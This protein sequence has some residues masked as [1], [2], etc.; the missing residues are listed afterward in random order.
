MTNEIF[1]Q[2]KADLQCLSYWTISQLALGALKERSIQSAQEHLDQCPRCR[3]LL[4]AE[5]EQVDA[6][7]YQRLPEQ[8]MAEI[9]K[10]E[11][12]TKAGWRLFFGSRLFF[13]GLTV[14]LTVCLVLVIS[15]IVKD[16]GVDVNQPLTRIKGSEGLT[17]S[18]LRGEQLTHN[19]VPLEQVSALSVGDRLR[20]HYQGRQD[21]WLEIYGQEKGI[22]ELYYQGK[23]PL[24]G[25][26][27]MG[28]K[29]TGEEITKIKVL[30]CSGQSGLQSEQI[31]DKSKCS[32][33]VFN[34]RLSNS[35]Q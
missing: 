15:F 30:E 18:V 35:S 29:I 4:R 14:S 3:D 34:L 26:L 16:M 20:L 17:V 24:D 28:I 32:Q 7:R 22:W 31:I 21:N 6:A 11:Q 8:L 23:V 13:P 5:Q 12:R 25:W 19:R 2:E 1:R 27:P 33:Q 10:D 9:E